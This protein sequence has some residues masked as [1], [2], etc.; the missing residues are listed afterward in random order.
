MYLYPERANCKYCLERRDCYTSSRYAGGNYRRP[1]RWYQ[2]RICFDCASHLAAI[3]TPG[4]TSVYGWD[5]L[6]LRFLVAAL[7]TPRFER[8][9]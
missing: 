6:S 2:S 9:T 3:V 1:G 8:I 4:H 7:Y 5:A